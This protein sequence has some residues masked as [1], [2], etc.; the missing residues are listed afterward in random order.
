MHDSTDELS[1]LADKVDMDPLR[2][3]DELTEFLTC[4]DTAH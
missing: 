1:A 4:A 2:I 3:M